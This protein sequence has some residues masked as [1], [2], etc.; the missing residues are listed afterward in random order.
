MSAETM[1][2]L[3]HICLW[4]QHCADFKGRYVS[5]SC[6]T[7]KKLKH[8]CLWSQH[9]VAQ[10]WLQRQICFNFSIVSAD[11]ISVPADYL[12][13]SAASH[14]QTQVQVWWANRAITWR[15]LWNYI[16]ISHFDK[17]N[18]FRTENI[19]TLIQSVPLVA[20]KVSLCAH[21]ADITMLPVIDQ[22]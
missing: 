20:D 17:K 8:I 22:H 6:E 15:P 1:E 21:A 12:T 11:I 13:Q 18:I 5:I 7:M 14:L 4:S 9:C 3:K 16:Y 19:S 2:K 10:C